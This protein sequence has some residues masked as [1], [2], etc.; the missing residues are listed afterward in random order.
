MNT[1]ILTVVGAG[2][3]TTICKN[4]CNGYINRGYSALFT[5]STKIFNEP[6]HN[7]YIGDADKITASKGFMIAAKSAIADGK[8]KGYTSDEIDIIAKLN[9]F[10]YI[11][12]EADGSQRKPIKAPKITEPVYPHNTDL[13]IGVIGASCLSKK[14]C[15]ESIYNLEHFC[16]ITQA[17]INDQITA[18]HITKLINSDSGLFSNSKKSIPKVVFINQSDLIRKDLKDNILNELSKSKYPVYLTSIKDPW[19]DKLYN[20]LFK[21]K[22]KG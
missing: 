2:G 22:Q 9:I 6:T 7:V 15:Y 4:I 16:N 12:I 13:L 14:V 18:K 8:L 5:T 19:Y 11:I 1:K 20:K 21:L 3:K 17:N 10:D